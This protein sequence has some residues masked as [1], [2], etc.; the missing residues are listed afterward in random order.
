[1]KGLYRGAT[2]FWSL[3]L[4]DRDSRI[5]FCG[6]DVDLRHGARH[7]VADAGLP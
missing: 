6:P 5:V 2:A 4:Q 1:M 7:G 3:Q